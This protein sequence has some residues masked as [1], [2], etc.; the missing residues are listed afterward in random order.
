MKT[1]F[2]FLFIQ[3][4]EEDSICCSPFSYFQNLVVHRLAL[5]FGN[6]I[7]DIESKFLAQRHSFLDK[8]WLRLFNFTKILQIYLFFTIK[9]DKPK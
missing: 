9:L 7:V 8:F 4:E 2:S 5:T 6:H 1:Y 3:G